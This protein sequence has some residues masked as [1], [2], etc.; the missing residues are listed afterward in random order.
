[1]A[2]ATITENDREDAM[3]LF[4][5]V[6]IVGDQ[7]QF[8]ASPDITD[9]GAG[10]ITVSIPVYATAALEYIV[11]LRKS[12]DDSQ[13]DA[14]GLAQV[15]TEWEVRTATLEHPG[16]YDV[17]V[18]I[19][20]S[21]SASEQEIWVSVPIGC[22]H[23]ASGLG[24]ARPLIPLDADGALAATAPIVVP[25]STLNDDLL[26]WG[27]IEVTAL[28]AAETTGE[29][30]SLVDMIAAES[31]ASRA[32]VQLR[33]VGGA[34]VEESLA[35]NSD[36]S[37][38]NATGG[39][40][41][42][43]D[44]PDSPDGS[45]ITATGGG[46]TETIHGFAAPSGN[47][48]AGAD[49]QT[50][51]VYVNHT[52]SGAITLTIKLREG[53]SD[54]GTIGS[55]SISADGVVEATWDAA[56][57]TDPSGADVEI[58]LSWTNSFGSLAIGAVEWVAAVPG[59]GSD[60]RLV[61]YDADTPTAVNSDATSD[62]SDW[63]TPFTARG[64]YSLCGLWEDQAKFAGIHFSD[65][66][67]AT[68]TGDYGRTAA[69]TMTLGSDPFDLILLGANRAVVDGATRENYFTG[70]IARVRIKSREQNLHP[71]PAWRVPLNDADGE[72]DE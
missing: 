56:D 48:V 57:L 58:G 63:V 24:H 8:L 54:L 6:S 45:E 41:N 21:N 66:D 23:D 11:T 68:S 34:A 32:I 69:W 10:D 40:G 46:A 44:D 28:A 49:L 36:V 47:P 31:A 7:T 25:D 16:G 27:E 5:A 42:I 4:R 3:R 18:A 19:H 9:P 17:Y 43:D 38:T 62:G 15:A 35:P 39:F 26:A 72:V 59:A 13:V 22:W 55:P 61:H 52:P 20:P 64:R 37:Q 70:G 67:F 12:S 51:R 53:G 71:P 14:V 2:V 60:L 1:M 33:D 65:D 30:R 29:V 50:F